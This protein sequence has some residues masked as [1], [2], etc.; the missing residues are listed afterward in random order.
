MTIRKVLLVDDDPSIRQM[1]GLGAK[2][3]IIKPFA[4]LFLPGQIRQHSEP[5]DS[6]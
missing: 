3:V 2:G 5:A 6:H 4:P 1:F